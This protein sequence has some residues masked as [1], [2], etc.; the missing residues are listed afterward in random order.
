MTNDLAA[1]YE[2]ALVRYRDAV[3]ALV[4]LLRRMAISALAPVLPGAAQLVT[5]GE[6]NEDSLSILRIRRILDGDGGVLCDVDRLDA[7]REVEDRVDLVGY[8]YLDRLLDLTG[9]EYYGEH[10]WSAE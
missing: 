1:S 3:R 9:D 6:V 10:R 5:F 2:A 7:T 8:E 4:P